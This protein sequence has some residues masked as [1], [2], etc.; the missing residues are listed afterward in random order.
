MARNIALQLY[1]LRETMKTDFLGT[2]GEVAKIGYAGVEMA[3]FGGHSA[4]ELRKVMDGLGLKVVGG[5]VTI[6]AITTS[7]AQTLDDYT[8]LGAKYVG[9]PWVGDAYRSA[10]GVKQAA[11]LMRD[12]AQEAATRGITF[13]YHNHDF[14]FLNRFGSQYMLDVLFAATGPSVKWESDVYWVQ[15]GGADPVVYL[16]NYRGRVPL[17]HIKDMTADASR[18][19][20]CIGDGIID[21]PAVFAAGDAC[22]ADWYIVEQD[23]CPK[24]EV[25]SA[26]RSYENIVR[27]GWL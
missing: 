4:K 24:G 25:A 8:A 10:E 20:E 2:L 5:H 7:L 18:T 16:N 13:F 27:R 9:V 12:A 3:G 1:T 19:F 17:V 23:Q 11:V 15:K 26:R 21:F 6:D 14:E 22:G